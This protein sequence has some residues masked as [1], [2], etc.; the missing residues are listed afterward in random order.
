MLDV[1]KSFDRQKILR[2]IERQLLYQPTVESRNKKK[3]K[4]NKLAQGEIRVDKFRI[5]Y[6]IDDAERS[7]KI[8]A[9][10]EKAGN[11][12]YILGGEYDL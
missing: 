8:S 5:F 2:E 10:G 1:L 7:V 11:R 9:I 3:L 12:L 6:D 4:P